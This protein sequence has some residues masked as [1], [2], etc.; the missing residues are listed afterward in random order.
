[1]TT[2]PLFLFAPGAGAPSSSAWMRRWVG[3][4]E[5][6]GRVATF[7][8]DYMRAG[9]RRPDPL[10]RL[11]AAH[12]AALAEARREGDGPVALIGKSMGGRV[13]CHVSL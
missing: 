11:I 9:S 5:T 1:M 13:G 3:R 12:R 2:Q 7:D 10:P 4:L 6:L 8:Y